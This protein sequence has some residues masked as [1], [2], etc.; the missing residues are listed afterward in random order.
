MNI[1]R[2]R[3][4]AG[5]TQE[6]LA[7]RAVVQQSDV[8]KWETDTAI[9]ELL[10]LVKVATVLRISINSL[11]VGL[12]PTY[13]AFVRDLP[14]HSGTLDSPSRTI[15][16]STGAERAH[17]CEDFWRPHRESQR[18]NPKEFGPRPARVNDA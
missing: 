18:E 8:S 14:S 10:S 1:R 12:E 15:G 6:Q 4:H 7:A 2:A 17:A 11:L 9:P 3:K 13:D 5:L 16:G